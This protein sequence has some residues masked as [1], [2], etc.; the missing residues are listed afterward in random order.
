M[1][2]PVASVLTGVHPGSAG[3]VVVVTGGGDVVLGDRTVDPDPAVLAVGDADT[4]PHAAVRQ[5]HEVVARRTQ[6]GLRIT[7]VM[8]RSGVQPGAPCSPSILPH[9]DSGM[10][11]LAADGISATPGVSQVT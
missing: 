1:A 2:T 7:S 10:K 3:D 4:A 9:H 8:A 11:L 6:R 5:K